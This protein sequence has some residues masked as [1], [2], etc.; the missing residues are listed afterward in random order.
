MISTKYQHAENF[1]SLVC[2]MFQRIL[3]NLEL[4]L[5]GEPSLDRLI[6]AEGGCTKGYSEFYLNFTIRRRAY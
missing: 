5:C 1:F 3:Y 2:P 4:R 6:K